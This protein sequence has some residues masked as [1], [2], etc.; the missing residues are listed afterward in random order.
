MILTSR[1]E[2]PEARTCSD[3]L[4]PARLH[5]EMG[6][7]ESSCVSHGTAKHRR[8]GMMRRGV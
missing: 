7:S 1:E 6:A 4:W 5:L 2:L 3:D 8:P